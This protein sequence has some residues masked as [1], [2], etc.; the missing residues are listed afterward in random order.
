[1]LLGEVTVQLFH[2]TGNGAQ[3]GQVGPVLLVNSS[4]G[5]GSKSSGSFNNHQQEFLITST[6]TELMDSIS[7]EGARWH[8]A[9]PSTCTAMEATY[10]VVLYKMSL[11]KILCKKT[12]NNTVT[13]FHARHTEHMLRRTSL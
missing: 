10:A 13:K 6:S 7:M 2:D 3:H 5:A 4:S 8:R 9:D 12:C 1:M 11:Y